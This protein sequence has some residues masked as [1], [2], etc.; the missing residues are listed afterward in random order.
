MGVAAECF[1]RFRALHKTL[2]T[3][4]REILE[5]CDILFLKTL[6]NFADNAFPKQTKIKFIN[7]T[8]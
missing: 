7:K 3:R 6:L 8:D 4:K 5:E 1:D 2:P